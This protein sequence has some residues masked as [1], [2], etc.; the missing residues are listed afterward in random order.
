[1]LWTTYTCNKMSAEW[2]MLRKKNSAYFM[3]SFRG[4]FWAKLSYGVRNQKTD[5]L[6]S[7]DGLTGKGHW[8]GRDVLHL[9]WG[10]G[11]NGRLHLSKLN[12]ICILFY[13][14]YPSE[15]KMAWVQAILPFF[16]LFPIKSVWLQQ[17]R[18]G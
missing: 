1:M 8:G 6:W 13:E 2:K 10:S 12:W 5:C 18:H 9:D 17:A 16:Y 7:Q 15:K 14:N 4:S 3:G 11:D